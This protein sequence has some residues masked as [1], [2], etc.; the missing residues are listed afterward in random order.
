MKRRKINL[1]RYKYSKKFVFLNHLIKSW[2]KKA[3]KKR[4]NPEFD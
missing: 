4:I 1:T 2:N 3:Y